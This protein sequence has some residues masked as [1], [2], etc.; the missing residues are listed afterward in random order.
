[1]TETAFG[2]VKLGASI[3]IGRDMAID[4][5]LI[6]PT[7]RERI[8]Q[9]RAAVKWKAYAEAQ[10]RADNEMAQAL[11]AI[12]DPVTAAIYSLHAPDDD[13]YPRC[14][15]CDFAGSEAEEPGWPCRTVI[16]LAEAHGIPTRDD[17][18]P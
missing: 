3:N 18:K 16:A 12:P 8:E 4:F 9:R 13:A 2:V 5:G 7:A 10:Q 15:G 11:S 14:T 1:M 6:P 17:V